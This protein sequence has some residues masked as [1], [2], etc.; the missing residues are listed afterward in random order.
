MPRLP[1]VLNNRVLSQLIKDVRNGLP[2]K[3][4][5]LKNKVKWKT[6]CSWRRKSKIAGDKFE[7]KEKLHPAEKILFGF[8]DNLQQARAN[9]E[10]SLVN[11]VY[12]A[13]EKDWRAGMELLK[14]RFRNS[15]GDQPAT[16]NVSQ[17]QAQAQISTN[18]EAV[19]DALV[20]HPDFV[21]YQRSRLEQNGSFL[22]PAILPQSAE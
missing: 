11:G 15:W 18:R 17:H 5:C 12:Q 14:R 2:Y 21:E 9:F 3:S 10:A 16:V 20:N 8:E 19:N 7:S 1:E 4:A 6:F 22:G 13:S